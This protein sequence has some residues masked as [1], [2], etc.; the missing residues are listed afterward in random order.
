MMTVLDCVFLVV[1]SAILII[2]IHALYADR[3]ILWGLLIL[4]SMV[5][6]CIFVL[7]ILGVAAL[8]MSDQLVPG[9]RFCA[10]MSPKL[11]NK[12]IWSDWVPILTFDT[13]L[14]LLAGLVAWRHRGLHQE[15]NTLLK[16]LLQG[17]LAYFLA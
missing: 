14:A 15:Y 16:T 11:L 1:V 4:L 8:K 17:S 13:V 3:R 9:V 10:S 2:R 5:G 6:T 12:L 7:S